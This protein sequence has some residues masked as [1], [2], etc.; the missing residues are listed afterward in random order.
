M[1]HFIH[2]V[3]KWICKHFGH[4]FHPIDVIIFQVKTNELNQDYSATITCRRCGV[5]IVH[6]NAG[7]T[8]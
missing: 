5:E 7:I 4:S 1:K 8:N 2:S 6:K 3:A